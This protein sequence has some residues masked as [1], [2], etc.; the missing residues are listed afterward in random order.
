MRLDSQ[1]QKAGAHILK[2]RDR[3]AKHSERKEPFVFTIPVSKDRKLCSKR[4]AK[5]LKH[6]L[7]KNRQSGLILLD[8]R[9]NIQTSFLPAIEGIKSGEAQPYALCVYE[10]KVLKPRSTISTIPTV[11]SAPDS[12]VSSFEK[13]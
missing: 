2:A 7:M 1:K 11:R 12:P 4:T 8:H 3:A 6:W 5:T 13:I 10:L 9:S